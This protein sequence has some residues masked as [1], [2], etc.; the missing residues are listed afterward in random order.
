MSPQAQRCYRKAV[1]FAGQGYD[2]LHR[3]LDASDVAALSEAFADVV[4]MAGHTVSEDATRFV[5]LLLEAVAA[6]AANNRVKLKSAEQAMD[7]VVHGLRG[8]LQA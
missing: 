1:N 6:G 4:L 7:I 2:S 8:E 5:D 3:A